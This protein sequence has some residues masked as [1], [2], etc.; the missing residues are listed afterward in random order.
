MRRLSRSARY[1][2]IRYV[3]LLLLLVAPGAVPSSAA[4]ADAKAD[5]DESGLT[6]ERYVRHVHVHGNTSYSEGTLKKLL[7]TRGRSFWKPWRKNPLRADY[8][9][10]DRTTLQDFYR[11]HGYLSAVVDSTS[12]RQLEKSDRADVHFYLTE[13]HRYPVE[14]VRFEGSSPIPETELREALTLREGDPFDVPREDLS[15]QA[16]ENKFLEKGYIAA[17]VRDSLEIDT[18]RVRIVHRI[19]TGPQAVLGA[20]KVEGT[21]STKPEFVTREVVLDPGDILARSKLVLSQQRIYDSGFYADVQFDRGAIDSVTAATDLIVGVRERKMGWIDMGVGYGTVDQVRLTTQV[22]QRNLFK[23]G[24]RF[25]ASGR[26]GFRVEADPWIARAGDRRLDLTLSRLWILGIRMTAALGTY[27]E[28]IPEVPDKTN[29]YQAYGGTM[30]LGYDFTRAV[31]ARLAYEHRR[32]ES[33]SSRFRVAFD[34]GRRRYSTNRIILTGER[35][36]RDN[37]FDSHRGMDIVGTSEFVGGVFRGSANFLKLGG[38]WSGYVPRRGLVLAVRLR[39]GVITPKG[40]D[41]GPSID[42]T[43]VVKPLDLIPEEDRYRTGGA[44]SVRGYRE[45]DIG[46]RIRAIDDTTQVI[47]RGGRILL[48]GNAELRFPIIGIIGGVAFFD[49]GNVWVR[50]TD[51]KLDRILSFSDE[52]GYND[53]RYGVGVGLRVGTPIGP[54]R[55]DYGWKLRLPNRAEPDATPGPGEFHFSVGQAF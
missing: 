34:A 54:L 10:F 2:L 47:E 22:G 19:E 50:R 37:A 55:F 32:I 23:D 11:R 15:R 44:N 49:A 21:A 39:G 20:V 12:T 51:I 9:R 27:A 36:T 29:A 14:S 28:A 40:V 6:L 38:N 53:M 3:V 7:R 43:I 16:V 45:N 25:V 18:T 48:Q 33:D 41:L 13:G 17:R 4:A 5:T 24:Y 30:T 46:T 31:R 35:D 52:A 26:L 1:L 42:S 8:I